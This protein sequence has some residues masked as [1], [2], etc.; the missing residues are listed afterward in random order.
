M[1]S[2]AVR[3]GF[4]VSVTGGADPRGAVTWLQITGSPKEPTLCQTEPSQK[5]TWDRPG[6]TLPVSNT[7]RRA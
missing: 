1:T 2:F 3:E 6:P 4:G 5:I 7:H